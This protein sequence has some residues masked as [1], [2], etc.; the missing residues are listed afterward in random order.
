MLARDGI[1]NTRC[2]MQTQEIDR[3][4]NG[5]TITTILNDRSLIAILIGVIVCGIALVSLLVTIGNVYL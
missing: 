3:P 4:L 1:K 5:K 2:R